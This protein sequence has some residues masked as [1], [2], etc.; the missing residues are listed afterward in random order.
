MTQKSLDYMEETI[1]SNYW[2]LHK[3]TEMVEGRVEKLEERVNERTSDNQDTLAEIRQEL[4]K[5]RA[6]IIDQEERIQKIEERYNLPI[7]D[8]TGVK[9]SKEDSEEMRKKY[10]A[11]ADMLTGTDRLREIIKRNENA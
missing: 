5:F 11:R 1:R 2:T 10:E 8:L 4:V 7:M 3:Y 6:I 9:V